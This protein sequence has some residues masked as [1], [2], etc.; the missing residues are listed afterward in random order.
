MVGALSLH[1]FVRKTK[2]KH[3]SKNA[4]YSQSGIILGHENLKRAIKPRWSKFATSIPYIHP[5]EY[6]SYGNKNL[7][8]AIT[9]VKIFCM[10]VT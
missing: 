7:Q 9:N 4:N 10:K 2:K 3:F 5:V 8:F 1:P 6:S